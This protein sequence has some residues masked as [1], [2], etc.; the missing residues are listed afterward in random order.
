[1]NSL[2]P[3]DRFVSE[4][5][6][7]V[8]YAETDAMRIVHHSSYIIYFE[9]ARSDYTRQRGSDYADFERGGLFLSVV[10][11]NARYVRPARYGQQVTIRTW[12]EAI[13]SRGLTFSYEVVDTATGAV[14]VTGTTRHICVNRDGQVAKIPEAWQQWAKS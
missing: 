9:E 7:Y 1:M 12:I 3:Q 8:R 5:T 10:E 13:Q 4:T 11:V 2:T 6:F 14:H